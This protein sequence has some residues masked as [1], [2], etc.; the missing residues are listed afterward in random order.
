MRAAGARSE[1]SRETRQVQLP[2]CTAPEPTTTGPL[3]WVS[4]NST[5]RRRQDQPDR[6]PN[7]IRA[8]QCDDLSIRQSQVQ[9]GRK[10][11]QD[12]DWS[13]RPT[14]QVPDPGRTRDSHLG[15]QQQ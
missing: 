12:S 4:G 1:T 7:S 6:Q 11:T 2:M 14:D 9:R 5:A 3:R 13:E 8:E 15:R 10:S